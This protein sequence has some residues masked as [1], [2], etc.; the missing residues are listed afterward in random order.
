MFFKSNFFDQWVLLTWKFRTV[1]SSSAVR[2]LPLLT[3]LSRSLNLSGFGCHTQR[4]SFA[5]LRSSQPEIPYKRDIH[6][7]FAKFTEKHMCWNVFVL[8]LQDWQPVTLLITGSTTI[9][10]WRIWHV[11]FILSY[12]KNTPGAVSFLFTEK[13]GRMSKE[14]CIWK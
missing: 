13:F 12:T 14:R 2:S 8:K 9:V 10:S 6:K 4:N 5:I 3:D 7:I 11:F 1:K